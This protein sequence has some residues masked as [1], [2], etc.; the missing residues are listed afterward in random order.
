MAKRVFLHVGTPK[1]GTTFLQSLLWANK[2]V[3]AS[4]G[5]LLPLNAVGDHFHLSIVGRQASAQ[6]ATMPERGHTS[7]QRMLDEVGPW[8]GD[9]VIS[10]ELFS[11]CSPRRAQW[12]IERLRSVADEV[13]TIVTGRDLARQVPAEWQQTIKHGRSHRLKEFYG[14]IQA[15]D[16]TVT[17]WRA[18]D[19]VTL[20]HDWS[21]GLPPDQVHLVTVPPAG[22]PRD[23]LWRRVGTLIGVDPDSVDQSVNQPNESLGLVEIETLRRVNLCVPTG[24]RSPRRQMLT[25]QVLAEGILAR[26]AGA[27]RFAPPPEEH[28]WVVERGTA[29]VNALRKTPCHVVGDLDELVPPAE[30]LA[31]P[32][33]DDVDDTLVAEVAVET[34]ARLLFRGPNKTRPMANRLGEFNSELEKRTAR[35]LAL[36]GQLRSAWAAYERERDLPLWKHAGRRVRAAARGAFRPGK[37]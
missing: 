27:A 34:I 19:L 32:S 21:Q 7:W 17:F 1:T 2:D 30:P 14:L 18:Q 6:L 10:H 13:H 22:A 5:V 12:C 15:Q 20:L 4:Q 24:I 37:D 3:L 25:R 16:P 35:V 33:P 23:L 8:S 9:A 36:E 31:G 29:M 28:A 26:R 11:M